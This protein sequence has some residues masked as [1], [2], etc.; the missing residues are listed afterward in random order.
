MAEQLSSDISAQLS[1][2]DKLGKFVRRPSAQ[3]SGSLAHNRQLSPPM[4]ANSPQEPLE[5]ILFSMGFVSTV[6]ALLGALVMPG[7]QMAAP[8]SPLSWSYLAA[9]TA[10]AF[11]VQVGRGRG[12]RREQ[13]LGRKHAH[14]Q[15]AEYATR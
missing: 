7:M 13:P 6:G 3:I 1:S 9:T 12:R 10:L 4:V 2:S 5:S 14:L 8:P 15:A 11:V